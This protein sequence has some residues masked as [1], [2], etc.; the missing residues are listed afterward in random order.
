MMLG[1]QWQIAADYFSCA[2]PF[3]I[4][5]LFLGRF[6]STQPLFLFISPLHLFTKEAVQLFSFSSLVLIKP[7]AQPSISSFS[8]SNHLSIHLSFISVSS[9][10]PV[11]AERWQACVCLALLSAFLMS[12]KHRGSAYYGDE[13][14]QAG[15]KVTDLANRGPLCSSTP[16]F[17]LSYSFLTQFLLPSIYK[18]TSLS[19]LMKRL[20]C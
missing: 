14:I 3:P 13:E 8:F 15:Q 4:K 12:L 7:G 16:P 20:I 10:S 2:H 9:R 17:S 11:G 18:S 1:L 5:L 6:I 19:C